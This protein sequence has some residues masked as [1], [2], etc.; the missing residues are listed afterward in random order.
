MSGEPARNSETAH[1]Q[2]LGEQRELFA[3]DGG[4]LA[5]VDVR[6][7][8][9]RVRTARNR[10]EG[11]AVLRQSDEDPAG[12]HNYFPPR[13]SV[14]LAVYLLGANALAAG[15]RRGLPSVSAAIAAISMVLPFLPAV[16]SL[17]R[18]SAEPMRRDVCAF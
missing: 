12:E 10:P 11:I 16:R 3:F 1:P 9:E 5:D 7:H 14:N 13:Q 15:V 8:A 18:P 2:S 4:I 6:G 17:L